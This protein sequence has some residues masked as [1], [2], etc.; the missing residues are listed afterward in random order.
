[1]ICEMNCYVCSQLLLQVH[2]LAWSAK[3]VGCDIGVGNYY[4]MCHRFYCNY[5]FDTTI[6]IASNY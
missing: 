6:A 3:A 5:C 1:M 2:G 4:V